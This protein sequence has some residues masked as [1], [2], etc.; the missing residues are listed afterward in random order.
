MN[1]TNQ[2]RVSLAQFALCWWRRHNRSLM[3]SQWQDNRDAITWIGISNSLDIVFIHGD[4]HGRS[5]KKPCHLKHAFTAVLATRS[6][7]WCNN[8]FTLFYMSN[9]F[10]ERLLEPTLRKANNETS[11]KFIARISIFN[12]PVS[13][14]ITVNFVFNVVYREHCVYIDTSYPCWEVGV[15]HVP[16]S[17]IKILWHYVRHVSMEMWV[18]RNVF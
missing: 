4:I 5:F 17:F 8:I 14:F 2:P 15:R 16:W 13:C 6:L 7:K 9:L 3:T 12:T 18:D 10:L 11:I 1:S